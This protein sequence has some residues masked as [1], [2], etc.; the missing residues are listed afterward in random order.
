MENGFLKKGN[1]VPEKAH[2]A[3]QKIVLTIQAREIYAYSH[4]WLHS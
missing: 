1:L 3:D 4:I 2:S